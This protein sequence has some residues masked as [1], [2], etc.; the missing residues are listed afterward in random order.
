MQYIVK[1]IP[2]SDLETLTSHFGFRLQMLCIKPV[3][4]PYT[5]TQV[6]ENKN[7]QF[8]SLKMYIKNRGTCMLSMKSKPNKH[9][10]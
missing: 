3:Q 8:G 4:L 10:L 5:L 1:R 6:G 7:D 9:V 2:I